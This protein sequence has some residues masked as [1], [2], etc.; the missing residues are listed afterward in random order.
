MARRKK[1]IAIMGASGYVGRNLKRVASS[2]Y[3][4]VELVPV[5]RDGLAGLYSGHRI[6]DFLDARPGPRDGTY[7]NGAPDRYLGAVGSSGLEDF[8]AQL[9][10]SDVLVNLAGSGR[11]SARNPYHASVEAPADLAAFAGRESG[12]PIVHMSGLGA[13]PSTPVAYLASKYAAE[14]AVRNSGTRYVVLRPSYI[15]GGGDHLHAYVQQCKKAAARKVGATRT[16]PPVDVYG[17]PRPI[18]PIH[19]DDAASVIMWAVRRLAAPG[20]G[21]SGGGAAARK[22]AGR[23]VT[24]DLVGP[25]RIPFYDYMAG[26]AGN[27]GAAARPVPMEQAYA[28]ALRSPESAPF[29]V[30]DLGIIAGGHTGNYHRLVETTGVRPRSVLR[31]LEAGGIP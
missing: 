20:G 24:L 26:L 7:R 23:G 29:G 22:G 9:K 13:S 10:D 12:I 25:D 30:D 3:P 28:L 17:S 21:G 1:R 2:R 14:S 11:Q 19:V 16:R 27:A 18:Q 4:N 6:Y 5:S 15:V 8:V 31:V